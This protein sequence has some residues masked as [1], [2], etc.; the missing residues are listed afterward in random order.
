MVIQQINRFSLS[1]FEKTNEM[2][3]G[4]YKTQKKPHP[5]RDET[6]IDMI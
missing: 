2:T 3:V 4:T 5:R 1:L 6:P